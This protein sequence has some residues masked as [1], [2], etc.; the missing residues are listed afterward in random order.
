MKQQ[1][2]DAI[3]HLQSEQQLLQAQNLQLKRMLLEQANRIAKVSRAILE[4]KDQKQA[5][6]R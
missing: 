4:L 3:T 5:V 6:M 1:E 2:P